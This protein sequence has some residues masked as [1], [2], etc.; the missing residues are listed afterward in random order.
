[1][2]NT[3][4]AISNKRDTHI[5]EENHVEVNAMLAQMK[6]EFEDLK[7]KNEEEVQNQKRENQRLKKKLEEKQQSTILVHDETDES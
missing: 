6:K 4:R 5:A 2:V 7:R 1:M 3:R